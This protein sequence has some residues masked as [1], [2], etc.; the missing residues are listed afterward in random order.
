MKAGNL[1]EYPNRMVN[2]YY[3][4]MDIK[5]N[6]TYLMNSINNSP[7][8]QAKE[9]EDEDYEIQYKYNPTREIEIQKEVERYRQKLQDDLLKVIN[10]EKQKEEERETFHK[11][12]ADEE[13]KKK[14][15]ILINLQ[16]S[17]S[18]RKVVTMKQYK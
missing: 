13:E 7:S 17:E 10:E 9:D 3:S 4:N 1:N 16:R 14:A 18:S 12:I 6:S 8:K 11:N 15:E 5:Q 2:T